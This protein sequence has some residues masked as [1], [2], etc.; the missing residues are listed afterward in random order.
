VVSHVTATVADLAPCT[1][2]PFRAAEQAEAVPIVDA[3]ATGELAVGSGPASRTVTL[4]TREQPE[5]I[6][7]GDGFGFVTAVAVNSAGV[8]VGTGS[9]PDPDHNW[10]YQSGEA[11]RL[12]TPAGRFASVRELNET[13]DAV[14]VLSPPGLVVWPAGEPDEPRV[15]DGRNL[16]PVG[17]R[18]DATVI[19]TGIDDL[20]RPVLVFVKPD[21]SRQAVRIPAEITGFDI[22][23]ARDRFG[24]VRGDMLFAT[25]WVGAVS[26]PLRWNLRTGQVEIFDNLTG[27]VTAG[28]A[29]GWLMTTDGDRAVAVSPD[30]A[31]RRLADPGSVVWVSAGGTVMIAN[32]PTGPV[33]W[34]C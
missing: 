31:G 5:A 26:H 7:P 19:A 16:E 12:P 8:V 23:I 2:V 11:R 30:G 34:R 6:A 29:G 24:F 20:Q 28:T 14:G 25:A 33:T 9:E 15:I 1:T 18:D 3:A 13:G 21:G 22:G 27:P 32:T 10:I 4:W 17:L